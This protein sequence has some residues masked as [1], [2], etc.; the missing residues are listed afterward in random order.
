[1]NKII[2]QFVAD[3]NAVNE[4]EYGDFLK[5]AN[6]YL[7]ELHHELSKSSYE[8]IEQKITEMQTYLQFRSNWQIAST[9]ERILKDAQI[10]DELWRGHEQDWESGL[11]R[12]F[13]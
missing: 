8:D 4:S 1:M 11:I 3:I 10:I 9:K 2:D 13:E 12:D 7:N 6:L 5:K